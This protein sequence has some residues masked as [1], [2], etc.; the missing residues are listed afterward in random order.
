MQRKRRKQYL[1]IDPGVKGGV[2]VLD[3]A[4]MSAYK[5][6]PTV[7]EMADLLYEKHLGYYCNY[8]GC[9]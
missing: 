8:R 3:G 7:K 5:C 9:S 1:A 4:S 6:P 2:A